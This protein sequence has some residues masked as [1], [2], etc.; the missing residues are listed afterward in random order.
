MGLWL[1]KG[2]VYFIVVLP[3]KNIRKSKFM[4]MTTCCGI[5]VTST[6]RDMHPTQTMHV[7]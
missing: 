7:H 3:P 6:S 1:S 4:Y 5:H 2:K